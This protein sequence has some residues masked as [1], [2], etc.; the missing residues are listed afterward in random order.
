M[1]EAYASPLALLA[2]RGLSGRKPQL[3]GRCLAPADASSSATRY[4]TTFGSL[5]GTSSKPPLATSG[6][7]RA[8]SDSHAFASNTSGACGRAQNAT[9]SAITTVTAANTTPCSLR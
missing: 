5:D 3:S 8:C 9:S 7:E 1:P 4:I 6:V 2:T